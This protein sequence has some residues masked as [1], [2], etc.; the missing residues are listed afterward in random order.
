MTK[1]FSMALK[2]TMVGRLTGVNAVSAAQLARETGITQQNFSRWLSQTRNSPFEAFAGVVVSAWNLE[3]KVRILAQASGLAGDELARYLESKPR[4]LLAR[5]AWPQQELDG[6]LR[7]TLSI[8]GSSRC[9]NTTH[10]APQLRSAKKSASLR[11]PCN[12]A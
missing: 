11:L 5:A 9:T 7:W 10:A 3:Q 1:Q 12:G 8:E 6:A 2:Q 4:S